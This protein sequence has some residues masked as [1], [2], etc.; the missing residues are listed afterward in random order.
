MLSAAEPLPGASRLPAV[1]S[2][3]LILS[4]DTSDEV[5]VIHVAGDLDLSNIPIFAAELGPSLSAP[6]LV[7]DFAA[8][9]FIDSS[10]LRELVRAHRVVADAGG[11]LVLVAPSE[12][13]RRVLEVATLDRFITVSETLAEALTSVA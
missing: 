4:T 5:A 9:T 11:R 8:C 7:V 10:A 12:P 6:L 13:V 1:P 2:N 3:A